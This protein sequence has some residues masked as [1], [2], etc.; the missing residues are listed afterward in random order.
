MVDNLDDSGRGSFRWAMD[1]ANTDIS[2]P[3]TILFT[4]SG[5]VMLQ[6][7]II[8]FYDWHVTILGSSAPGGAHSV[9]LDGSALSTGSGF[10]LETTVITS[11]D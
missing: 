4:V 6:T 1:S 2:W 9:I 3:D 5:T 8:P 10:F 7:G 11:R